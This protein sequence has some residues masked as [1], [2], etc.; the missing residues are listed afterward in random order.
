MAQT[1][2]IFTISP[3]AYTRGYAIKLSFLL[4]PAQVFNL[5]SITPPKDNKNTARSNGTQTDATIQ[6]S[7]W[8]GRYFSAMLNNPV[9]DEIGTNTS[10]RI[11]SRKTYFVSNEFC[12]ASR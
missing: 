1:S 5:S 9:V 8:P 6:E 2:I 4:E 11:V 3:R 10:A 12:W 7:G